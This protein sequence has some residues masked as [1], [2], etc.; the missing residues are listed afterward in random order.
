MFNT[1]DSTAGTAAARY[2][3]GDIVQVDDG[4]APGTTPGTTDGG[5]GCT[6]ASGNAPIDPMLPLLA[7]LGL[8]GWV[9]RRERRN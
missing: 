6:T 2:R 5:G 4:T 3:S 9:L 7:A 1:E 8:M